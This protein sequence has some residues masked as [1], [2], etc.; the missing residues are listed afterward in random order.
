MSS[1]GGSLHVLGER[2]V[3][4]CLVLSGVLS[5]SRT[6]CMIQGFITLSE[7]QSCLLFFFCPCAPSFRAQSLEPLSV[8]VLRDP[9]GQRSLWPCFIKAMLLFPSITAPAQQPWAVGN[10]K[11]VVT[12]SL[13]MD[14]LPLGLAAS[15]TMS[16][17]I[18]GNWGWEGSDGFQSP[19]QEQCP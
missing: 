18:G 9:T 14:A 16:L 3:E 4:Q 6:S 17:V 8:P 2:P 7:S 10:A 19:R 5:L 15:G 12:Q 1:L 13:G 11:P